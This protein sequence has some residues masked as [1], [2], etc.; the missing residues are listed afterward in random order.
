MCKSQKNQDKA[1]ESH[2]HTSSGCAPK[3]RRRRRKRKILKFFLFVGLLWATAIISHRHGGKIVNF[4]KLKKISKEMS[5]SWQQK[6][7]LMDVFFAARQKSFAQRKELKKIK[8]AFYKLMDKER[9]TQKELNEFIKKSMATFEVMA[10][11]QSKNLLKA[12]SVLSPYQRKLLVVRLQQM[13][14]K[15]NRRYRR[16]QKLRQHASAEWKDEFATYSNVANETKSASS[17]KTSK[18]QKEC[19]V[20]AKPTPTPTTQPTP[21]SHGLN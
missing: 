12:R 2:T 8:N 21:I 4:M 6:D 9:L 13:E 11:E 19:Q 15:R 18:A 7:Q 5:L 3:Q 10:L 14:R 1:S 17:P 20:Y 16:W